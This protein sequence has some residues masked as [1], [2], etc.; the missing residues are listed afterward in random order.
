MEHILKDLGDGRLIDREQAVLSNMKLVYRISKKYLTWA[1]KLGVEEED[2]HSIGSIGLMKAF[3]KWDPNKFEGAVNKFSTYAF[4]T[5]CGEIQRYLRD[6][7]PG[8]K[9]SRTTKS[10]AYQI[11]KQDIVEEDPKIIS[12]K[13][14]IPLKRVKDALVYLA[15]EKPVYLETATNEDSQGKTTIQDMIGVEQDTSQIFVNEFIES[16]APNLQTIALG[17][18]QGM[19]QADIGEKIGISQPQ[20]SRLIKEL[21]RNLSEY[22]ESK[23]ME[24]RPVSQT[25]LVLTKEIYEQHKEKSFTDREIAQKFNLEPQMLINLKQEWGESV[26]KVTPA[27]KGEMKTEK[28]TK[29][30]AKPKNEA[31]LEKEIAF[32]KQKYEELEEKYYKLEVEFKNDIAALKRTLKLVI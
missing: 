7:N 25:T 13:L 3:D 28:V 19:N 9:F 21:K 32:W 24:E 2:L 15:Q 26:P 23:E 18:M 12:E 22:L 17:L 4:P 14:G 16:L 8:A 1:T 6:A 30:E 11:V 10:D 5:I 27:Q 31:Y 29:L 20:V